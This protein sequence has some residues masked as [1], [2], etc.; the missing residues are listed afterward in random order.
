MKFI[1]KHAL[2]DAS[3]PMWQQDWV[4]ATHLFTMLNS[5]KIVNRWIFCPR[6]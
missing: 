4:Y 2:Y 6:W 1:D 3:K 5:N